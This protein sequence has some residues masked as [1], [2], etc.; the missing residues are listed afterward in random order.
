MESENSGSDPPLCLL[1]G[2]TVLLRCVAIG[3]PRPELIFTKA[4]A[5]IIVGVG[6][7]NRIRQV[8][9]DQVR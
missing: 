5:I 7:Y 1:A 6:V 3:Y 4:S 8:E 9:Y 2:S